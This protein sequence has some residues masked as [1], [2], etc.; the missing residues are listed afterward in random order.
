MTGFDDRERQFEE[1]FAHDEELR[2]KARARRAKLVG[3]W[4]AGLMGL[5]GKAAEDYALSLVAE[6]LKE[7]GDQDIIDKLMA[8]FRAHGV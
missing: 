7:T 1:K 4:A 3:L 5:E 8:D 2:F 6:D